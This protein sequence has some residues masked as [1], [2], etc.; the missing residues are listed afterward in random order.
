MPLLGA[1]YVSFSLCVYIMAIV[2][3]LAIGKS[4]KSAGNLTYKT[5][6]GRTIASQRITSNKSNTAKQQ[7][8]RDLFKNVSMSIALCR[9][10]IDSCYEKSKYGSARN[11][12][13]R[14]NPKF[15]LGHWVGEIKEGIEP[16]AKGFFN[17]IS[18]PTS[19]SPQLSVMTQGSLAC[20]P[21]I[22]VAVY[23]TY[24]ASFG[25]QTNIPYI[26]GK[27]VYTFPSGIK[28]SDV[29]MTIIGIMTDGIEAL[30]GS[31]D[32][33]GKFTAAEVGNQLALDFGNFQ[34]TSVIADGL[35]SSITVGT[36]TASVGEYNMI[37]AVPTSAGKVP[38][39]FAGFVKEV[40]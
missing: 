13:Q 2:N 34:V 40:A 26:D 16:F 35:I 27:A 19:G 23:P 11:A 1:G 28:F 17:A 7:V 39:T 33:K 10:Y 15:T 14:Q 3:S 31:F 8:Q 5:V 6:R 30:T 22:K 20:V 9:A 12:F 18:R 24:N 37:I 38:T 21:Q 25:E 32:D 4:V 36:D 29:S